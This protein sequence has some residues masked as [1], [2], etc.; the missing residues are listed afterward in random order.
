MNFLRPSISVNTP[1]IK[2]FSK[3]LSHKGIYYQTAKLWI[4]TEDGRK[5]MVGAIVCEHPLA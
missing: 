3:F 2:D 1:L 4:L 5:S